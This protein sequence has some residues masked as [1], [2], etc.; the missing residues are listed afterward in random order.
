MGRSK[1]DKDPIDPRGLIADAYAIEGIAEPECRSIFLDWAIG[2]PADEDTRAHIAVLLSRHETNP[3]HP[4]TRVLKAGLESPK[5]DGRRGGRKG[6]LGP[7]DQ[8]A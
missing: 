1:K 8:L 4:M 3:E 6:R 5:R 2:V 7:D